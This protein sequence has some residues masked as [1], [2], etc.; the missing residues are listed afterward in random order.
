P[1]GF[2]R[3]DAAL[4]EDPSGEPVAFP[5]GHCRRIAGEPAPAFLQR[6]TGLHAH[7]VN[8]ILVHAVLLLSGRKRPETGVPFRARCCWRPPKGG[9]RRATAG[10][11]PCGPPEVG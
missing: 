8:A 6:P 7:A 9:G 3:G 2:L 10:S 5:R 11:M 1:V 4:L